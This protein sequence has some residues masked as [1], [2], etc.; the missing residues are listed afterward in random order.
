M[1]GAI[2][3]QGRLKFSDGLGRFLEYT[4]CKI[5]QFA[6]EVFQFFVAFLRHDGF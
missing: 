3:Q 2:I 1:W 4:L 5:F 6:F